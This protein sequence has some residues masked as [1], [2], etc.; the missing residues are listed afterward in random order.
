[1]ELPTALDAEHTAARGELEKAQ[2]DEFDLKYIDSQIKDHQKAVQLLIYEI[3]S[4][5]HAGVRKFAADTLPA[6]MGHLEMARSVRAQ[7]VSGEVTKSDARN[8]A[9]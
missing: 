4:G 6:V 9:R 5:Q 7:L 1:V 2:G 8:A 3:A